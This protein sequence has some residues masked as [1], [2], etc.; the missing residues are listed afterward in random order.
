[1]KMK[2]DWKKPNVRDAYKPVPQAFEQ[3]VSKAIREIRTEEVQHGPNTSGYIFWGR[4]V[5]LIAAIC[6]LLLG[7]A[8]AYAIATR[9]AI[10]NWLIGYQDARG[11]QDA[12]EALEQA[13]QIVVAEN[14]SDHIAARINSIVYDGYQ[15]A[16]SYELEND[17]P[18]QP[19]M[20]VVDSCAFVNGKEHELNVSYYDLRLVPDPRQDVLPVRRNPTDGG[21]W[22]LPIH[23]ELTGEVTC[24]VTFI[25]YRPIK[26]FVVVSDPEDPIYHL[27]EYNKETQA[28]IQDKWNTLRGFKNMLIADSNDSDPERWSQQGYTVIHDGYVY[29][30]ES[31]IG[32]NWDEAPLFNMHETARIPVR[33]TFNINSANVYEFT[34]TDSVELSDCTLRIHHL[35]FSP[36]TTIVDISLIPKENTQEAAQKLVERYGT[37]DLV[38]ESGKPL[39]YSSMDYEFNPN[40]WAT[41]HWRDNE[42]WACTY[43]IEMPGLQ[44]WPESIS[45]VTEQGEILS[46][47][48]SQLKEE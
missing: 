24:E 40:P 4:R 10:L 12:N 15:F 35:R 22:S 20:V 30:S 48:I 46:L 36:L 21:A 5:V 44:V 23:Q 1:M 25:V 33:F 11:Y 14:S 39:N 2:C 17:Q 6:V 9:P 18:D 37:M 41:E 8:V 19:A 47:N 43:M 26:E 42:C 38:D 16:L 29:M 45:L 13:A 3:A 34:D 32:K 28:E 7:M 27:D 31:D